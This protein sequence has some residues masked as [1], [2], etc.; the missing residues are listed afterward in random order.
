MKN[1]LSSFKSRMLN[2]LLIKILKLHFLKQSKRDELRLMI[3]DDDAKN[4]KNDYSRVDQ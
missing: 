1:S 4:S 2:D 3:H